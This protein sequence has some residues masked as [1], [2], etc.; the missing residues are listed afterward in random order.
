LTPSLI[1][2]II[3]PTIKFKEI[4][5]MKK[6]YIPAVALLIL[7][8]ALFMVRC[9]GSSSSGGGFANVDVDYKVNGGSISHNANESREIRDPFGDNDLLILTWF[10][11]NYNGGHR[12]KVVL[13]FKKVANIWQLDKTEINDGSC[14]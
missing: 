6:I 4:K 11:G 13:T 9:V 14:G 8:V 2:L 5:A 10:C 3:L 7:G 1:Y 12:Q